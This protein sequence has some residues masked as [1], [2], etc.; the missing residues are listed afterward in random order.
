MRPGDFTMMSESLVFMVIGL[1]S[2]LFLPILSYFT[3][4]LNMVCDVYS[5]PGRSIT[6]GKLF[7]LGLSGKC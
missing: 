4:N 1:I 5:S 6:L 7:W 2:L 3:D